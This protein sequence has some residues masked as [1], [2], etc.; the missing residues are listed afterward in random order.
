M[1]DEEGNNDT[2]QQQ[3]RAMLLL[4]PDPSALAAAVSI[5]EPATAPPSSAGQSPDAT[6]KGAKKRARSEGVTGAAVAASG[7]GAGK[8]DAGASGPAK[9]QKV[10]KKQKNRCPRITH[11]STGTTGNRRKTVR[12][13]IH[14]MIQLVGL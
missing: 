8:A 13:N 11:S 10:E 6:L 1:S 7:D 14:I 9:K 3:K 5:A 2:A 4:G 12:F